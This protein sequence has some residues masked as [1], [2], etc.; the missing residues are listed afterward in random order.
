MSN[1]LP[2]IHNGQPNMI[3]KKLD[4]ENKVNSIGQEKVVS[5]EQHSFEV[6]SG[7]VIG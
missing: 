7:G 2:C 5:N 1:D 3:D 4:E 6:I